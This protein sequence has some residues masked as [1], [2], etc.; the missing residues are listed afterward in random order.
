MLVNR[1]RL[2]RLRH[3]STAWHTALDD[4]D[5]EFGA[6]RWEDLDKI[7]GASHEA[8]LMNQ[9]ITSETFR[10]K[11]LDYNRPWL[12]AQLPSILTPRTLRRSRPYLI[13]QLTQILGSVN[14]D[15]SSDEDEDDVSKQFGP[16]SLSD[17]SRRIIR[18][19]LAQARRRRTLKQLVQPLINRARKAECEQC[20]SRQ[21]LQVELLTPIDKLGDEYEAAFPSD[22]FDQ[23][24]WKAFFQKHAKFKTLCLECTHKTREENK[25]KA[26]NGDIDRDIP[27]VSDQIPATPFGPVALS[28]TSKAILLM[29]LK[30]AQEKARKRGVRLGIRKPNVSDDDEDDDKLDITFSKS[31]MNLSSASIAIMQKWLEIGRARVEEKGASTSF[32]RI[33]KKKKKKTPSNIF[34]F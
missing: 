31:R 22:E 16:V 3:E 17:S 34:G 7:K 29:W 4:D 1:S 33:Q 23:V 15:I 2:W 32:N 9:R 24:G 25:K 6:G 28:A 13:N 12:V 10:H 11:F 26:A 27:I 18:L 19:W 8:Y 20:L 14:P 30:M 21:Q 5:D